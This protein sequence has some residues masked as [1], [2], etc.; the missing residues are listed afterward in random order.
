MAPWGGGPRADAYVTPDGDCIGRGVI[1]TENHILLQET[2]RYLVNDLRG[3]QVPENRDWIIMF[4]QQ[5]VRRDL[6]EFNALPYS[7]YQLKALFALHDYAPDELVRRAAEGVLDWI[8]AKQA[9]S[10]NLDRDHRPYRRR[11]DSD[12]L[13]AKDWWSQ[14][15][16]AV[17][18]ATAV[19]AGPMQ[20]VHNDLDLQLDQKEAAQALSGEAV[21]MGP[22]TPPKPSGVE[23]YPDLGTASPY[24]AAELVD[25]A[26]THYSLPKSLVSWFER[27]F[28]IEEANRNTYVQGIHHDFPIGDDPALFRQPNSGVELVSG[29][30]NW[31][32]IAGGTRA[33]PGWPGTPPNRI[34]GLA[35]A[36]FGAITD[37]YANGK[38]R[39]AL[40]DDQPGIIRETMLIPTPV[41]LSREQ[42]IRFQGSMLTSRNETDIDRLC[43]AEGF[44]CGFDLRMPARA[45]PSSDALNCPDSI[46][47]RRS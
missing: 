41:G 47:C 3:A 38:Q 35:G 25:I 8:F 17:A 37:A 32:I 45:F 18:T 40:W 42:T 2:A 23:M 5:L 31:T 46:R 6:Y 33:P 20:H 34:G 15:A 22:G 10:G 26:N 21:E 36:Q 7:R 11:P 28:A 16:T 19:L 29:N 14:A 1:E 12:I 39:D 4:L 30:R 27:R 13:A 44:L 24:L 43:V 9:I